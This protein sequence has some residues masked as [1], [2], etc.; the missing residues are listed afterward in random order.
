MALTY[1]EIKRHS[2]ATK[3]VVDQAVRELERRIREYAPNGADSYTRAEIIRSQVRAVAKKYGASA[4]ELGAQWYEYCAE[5]AGVKVEP[6]LVGEIDYDGID[7]HFENLLDAYANGGESWD[8][9]EQKIRDVFEGE[10][11]SLERE[12]IIENLDRD[13][14]YERRG[15]GRYNAGFARVPVGETCAWCFMLA[16]LGYWYRSYESA[17]GVDPDHYHLHCDCEVVAYNDP[18]S[19]VGYDDFDTYKDMYTSAR[20]AYDSGDYSPE[21]AERIARAEARHNEKYE[22]G[23]YSQPWTKYNGV[24]MVMREQQG[25]EH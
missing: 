22:R 18:E 13:N 1:E 21:L 8:S 4:Q 23:D 9:I 10:L 12:T 19:I 7:A 3:K 24:L 25:L 17:G 5:K 20:D 2:N 6:A 14:T 11:R 16:S 15:R